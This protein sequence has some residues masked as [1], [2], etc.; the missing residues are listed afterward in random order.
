MQNS[1]WDPLWHPARA[2]QRAGLSKCLLTDGLMEGKKDGVG[3]GRQRE[4]RRNLILGL[5][6]KEQTEKY[7]KNP[8]VVIHLTHGKPFHS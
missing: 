2:W 5:Q 7:I 4:R 8:H 1:F 6:G 3:E